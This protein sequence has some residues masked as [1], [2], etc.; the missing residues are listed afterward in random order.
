MGNRRG[1]KSN[2]E[3]KRLWVLENYGEKAAKS[4]D[5]KTSLAIVDGEQCY[6][7]D[8]TKPL[9]MKHKMLADMSACGIS[10][11]EI[12]RQMSKHGN[13]HS[14]HNGNLLKDPRVRERTIHT[15]QEMVAGAKETIKSCVGQAAEN[16]K[17]SVNSGDLKTSKFVLGIHGIAEQKQVQVD[18][19]FSF[20]EW[21]ST[22]NSEAQGVKEMQHAII[23]VTADV[24]QLPDTRQIGGERLDEA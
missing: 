22:N 9:S 4:F 3:A 14:A 13:A 18:H 23:D 2:T 20:G 8:P 11:R 12:T 19:S 17:D 21:L 15:Q 6:I 10:T 24:E 1:R 7:V 16:I 5:P